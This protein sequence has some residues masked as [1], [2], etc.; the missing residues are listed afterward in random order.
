MST[1]TRQLRKF[2]VPDV[3]DYASRKE[4]LISSNLDWLLNKTAVMFEYH[5]LPPTIPA[6]ALERLLQWCGSCVIYRVPSTHMPVGYGASF[7]YSGLV[8]QTASD[9]SPNSRLYAFPYTLADA[10]DPYNEPFRV[11]I[12][13]P[14]FRPTI[15]STLEINKD[16]VIIRNDTNYRGL[17]QLHKKYAELLAEAEI[18]LR[19]TLLVLRDQLLF[20]AKT[21]KQRKSVERYISSR[22]L[23]EP[24]FI[25]SNDLGTPLET[26]TQNTHSNAVELAVNGL[27]A[28]KAAWYNEIGLDP[29]FS[30]KREYTSAQ[31]IDTNTDLL[32]PIIDDMYESRRIG[33]ENVNA[34]FGT[35]ITVQRSSAWRIK[36]RTIELGQQLEQAQVDLTEAQATA[37]EIGVAETVG[38]VNQTEQEGGDDSNETPN[39]S[40]ADGSSSD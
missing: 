37:A 20:I 8:D 38:L 27:Q 31:E 30:L 19:S 15:S 22:D 28:I 36:E 35:C 33:I 3:S 29:S 18:S 2:L 16:V 23:G 40:P 39:P 10:P 11:V 34:L 12:T 17:Y 4:R 13:S 7:N 25:T 26:I 6:I 14:G 9:S 1:I 24:S 5:N 21:E 32:M